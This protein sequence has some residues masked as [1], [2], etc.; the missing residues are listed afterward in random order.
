MSDIEPNEH[1]SWRDMVSQTADIVGDRTIAKW[2]CE[3]ASGCEL[4]EFASIQDE[5]VTHRSAVHLDVMVRR[6]L[7]G[8]PVQ[9]VMG[10]WAFRHLDLMVDSRVLIPRPE[11]ELLP[12]IVKR[13][14]GTM[15]SPYVV[16]DLG[17]GS[18]A[19]GLSLLHELPVDSTT[20]WMTDA[21]QDAIDV[22]RANG[23]GIGRHASHAR[24]AVGEWFNALSQD[25]K[26]S[27]HVLVSN[28]PYI[29]EQDPDVADSVN[30]WEPHK[31]LFAGSDGLDDVRVIIKEA[32]QWLMPG[33]LLAVE[34]G[35]TQAQAVVELFG[36]AG[37]SN[38]TVHQDLAG[39][40]RFVSG[41]FEN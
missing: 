41:V 7:A 36:N 17:T 34:M 13:H 18:G 2:L 4:G 20:V 9:Y 40:D 28:P 22:A 30:K 8:E 31:A 24:F 12:E 29:A 35:Y 19:I 37:F 33:G 16:G 11:T 14:L 27:F 32:P 5:L 38:V 25:L 6:Y 39:K 26:K 15:K 21:S 23:V 3:H 1:I 10:R